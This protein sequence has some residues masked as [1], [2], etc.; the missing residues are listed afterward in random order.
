M[1]ALLVSI[2]IPTYNRAATYLPQALASAL[3]QTYPHVE[4]IVSDNAS[5]DGTPAFVAG[6][7]DPRVRYIRHPVGIGANGNANFCLDQARGEYF[8]LL[9]DDDL[10]DP[11]FVEACLEAARAAPGAGV[12]R[13][14]TR[15]ISQAGATQ[16]EYPNN[17]GGL[18]TGAFFL[19]YFRGVTAFYFCSTL[20][21][22]RS[23]RE[24][25]GLRS[26]RSRLEDCLAIVRLAARYGRA[27]VRAVKAS[28][29]L[30][31]TKLGLSSR[32][33]EWCED[34]LQLLEE[35]VA[36]APQH[37]ASLRH[38]GL[39]FLSG[40]NYARAGKLTHPLVRVR[41]YA[42]IVRSFG[43]RYPP[44]AVRAFVVRNP[45][46]RAARGLVARSPAS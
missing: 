6:I 28:Y 20:F 41:A 9:H 10:L 40:R 31:G 30:H 21:H 3:T 38:E 42:T 11:D 44:P 37:R 36:L 13:T 34:S 4:I 17:A 35:M 23:L 14:G 22:A 24:V 5:S 19:G 32:M 39:K 16:A 29:R 26:R 25:G 43:W 18:E 12:I 1:S 15:V 45:L 33:D 2:G 8:L 7:D 27:D 46:Y